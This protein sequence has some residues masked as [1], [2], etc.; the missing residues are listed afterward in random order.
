MLKSQANTTIKNVQK[1]ASQ[2]ETSALITLFELDLSTA[3]ENSDIINNYD[4]IF[5][6][7]NNVKLL[8]T[9][10]KFQDKI[11]NLFPI[12]TNGFEI[13]SQGVLPT[14]TL[15]MST[16]ETGAPFLTMLKQQIKVLGDLVGCKL[17]RR[18]TFAKFLP[19]SNYNL[20][21]APM[22]D[23]NGLPA[24][25]EVDEFAEL[26]RDIWFINRKSTENKTTIEY[27]LNSILDFENLKLPR[28]QMISQRCNFQYRGEG[29]LYEY[30]NRKID[31]VHGETSIL[32]DSAPPIAT[33]DDK[34]ITDII[35]TTLKSDI[36]LYRPIQ[37]SIGDY[38]YIEKEGIKYYFV[39]KTAGYLS[40]PPNSS[41]W[42]A[43]KCSKCVIGCKLRWSKTNPIGS[44]V[45]NPGGEA[46]LAGLKKGNLPFGGFPSLNRINRQGY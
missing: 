2:L 18:R 39:A 27:E 10:I 38:V 5:Y 40:V 44:V 24:N 23:S 30:S 25:T 46:D 33:E 15:R 4:R 45:I 1:E 26:P 13:T 36:G 43:D 8:T 37:Y 9:S 29:C 35:N 41:Q 11:Y 20:Y 21:N 12:E 17:T 19:V 3:L 34:L 32:P 31:D 28:R 22:F 7:H 16:S 42:V 14:P 6:F